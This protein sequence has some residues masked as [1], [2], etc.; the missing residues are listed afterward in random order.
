MYRGIP[1]RYDEMLQPEIIP[2]DQTETIGCELWLTTELTYEWR[3]TNLIDNTVLLNWHKANSYEQAVLE[4][5]TC[6]KQL[7]N[8]NQEKI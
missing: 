3:I 2:L 1:G 6:W 7:M 8:F 5:K 4:V